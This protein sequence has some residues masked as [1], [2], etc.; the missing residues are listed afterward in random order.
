MVKKNERIRSKRQTAQP[1]AKERL[2]EEWE[3]E[4]GQLESRRKSYKKRAAERLICWI[5]R[6]F[7]I[8]NR[9]SVVAFG[10]NERYT[11]FTRPSTAWSAI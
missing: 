11:W 8:H 2:D 9:G 3:D 7:L 6:N 4:D 1:V 10:L 5:S